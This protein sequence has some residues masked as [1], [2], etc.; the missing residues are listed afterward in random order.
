[1]TNLTNAQIE[2][3]HCLQEEAS[4]IIQIT[5][6][7][8][9]HGFESTNPF[10]ENQITNKRN[11]EKELGDLMY[12]VEQLSD[13][14]DIN[15]LNVGISQ[16]DKSESSKKIHILS[17]RKPS[18][19]PKPII[20]QI[21][22]LARSGKD[23]TAAQLKAYFE[24]Q[25]KSVEIMSYAAPMKRMTA[26][27]FNISLDNLD[28]YKNNKDSIYLQE[29]Y[30][31]AEYLTDF[32]TFLQTLG[33]E[34]MKS[35]FGDSVWADLM[36]K[37]INQSTADIVIIPD[38]RFKVELSTVGGT[39]IRVINNDLTPMSHPSETELSDFQTDITINNTKHQASIELIERLGERIL[40][41]NL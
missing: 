17:K 32:R 20:I 36:L 4:E 16:S 33:N 38:C 12:W 30:Q 22:G 41:E 29:K 21:L 9:R 34:A 2:R 19:K 1:M 15:M 39:T 25:S 23:W 11:L 13:N 14:S 24:S 35:E 8:L 10:D 40:N 26:K 37:N 18:M 3:L 6:K 27:L 31:D 5:S 7:I 28:S